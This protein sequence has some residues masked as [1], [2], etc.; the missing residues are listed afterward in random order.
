MPDDRTKTGKAD[1][2]RINIHEPY[3]LR[4]WSNKLGVTPE[5]LKQAVHVVG[6]MVKDVKRYLGVS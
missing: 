6:P 2:I 5:R 4:D 1:D 3:E